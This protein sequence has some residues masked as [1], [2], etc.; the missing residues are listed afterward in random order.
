MMEESVTSHAVRGPS[1]RCHAAVYVRA[2]VRSHASPISTNVHELSIAKIT[3]NSSASH[4]ASTEDMPLS[5]RRSMPEGSVS[6]PN[7]TTTLIM[8]SA[9]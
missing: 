8:F 3:S 6:T 2:P 4:F 5:D 7:P 1:V 9:S